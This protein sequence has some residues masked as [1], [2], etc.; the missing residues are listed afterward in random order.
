MYAYA[1]CLCPLWC[2]EGVLPQAGRLVCLLLTQ[3]VLVQGP[4]GTGKTSTILGI[5]SALLH[6]CLPA[7][8][9]NRRASES[10]DGAA[11]NEDAGAAVGAAGAPR[12][13]LKAPSAAAR[14]RKQ[15]HGSDGGG[16][17]GGG[18]GGGEDGAERAGGGAGDEPVRLGVMPKVRVLICAQSNAGERAERY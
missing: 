5:T 17:G 10:G 4:P 15:Q 3:V 16:G 14:R 12:R 11:A 18:E 1:V 9:A 6:A 8:N 13:Q 7:G 2:P